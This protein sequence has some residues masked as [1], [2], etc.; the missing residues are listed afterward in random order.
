ML[1]DELAAMESAEELF[2]WLGQAYDPA[3]LRIHR[4]RILKRFGRALSAQGEPPADHEQR[5][6]LCAALLRQVYDEVARADAFDDEPALTRPPRLFQLRRR[7]R[8]A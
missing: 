7:S 8:A 1:T 3:V 5:R 4:V 2:A 6:K